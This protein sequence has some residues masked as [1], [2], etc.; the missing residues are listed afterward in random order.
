M[1][2]AALLRAMR[3]LEDVQDHLVVVGGTAHRLFPLHPLAQDPGFDLLTTEDIDFAAPLELQHD[4]SRQ[5]LDR[6]LEAGFEE[7]IRGAEYPA[8][9]YPLRGQE[10]TYLQFV[11]NL[12][13]S[14]TTRS[15]EKDRL[16]SF[17][18]IHAEKLR[19]IDV[20]LHA[21]WKVELEA[22]GLPLSVRVVNPSAYLLQK[23]LTLGERA[24]PK[25]A[26][27]LLY[28]FD[29]LTLFGESL[30]ALGEQ[31]QALV[32]ELSRKTGNKIKK[33]A[34]TYCFTDGPAAHEAAKIAQEQRQSPPT[35]TQIVSA[36]EFALPRVLPDL[37]GAAS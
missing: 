36:C 24:T 3:A 2:D 17:S 11:A 9:T 18:G 37:L 28:I 25:R 32:P 27:D 34:E 14:G 12:T 23:L 7:S 5:L 30:R 6:L 29:T 19:H 16:M 26:K 31:A 33:A 35:A 13:G 15:G 10:R 8:F 21:A 22:E 4:G 20:L 1:T